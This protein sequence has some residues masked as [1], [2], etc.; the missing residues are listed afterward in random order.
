MGLGAIAAFQVGTSL[1]RYAGARYSA[2]KRNFGRTAIGQKLSQIEK[3]GAISPEMRNQRLGEENRVL[4]SQSSAATAR[5]RGGLINRGLDDSIAGVRAEAAPAIEKLRQLGYS[6]RGI[7]AENA[8]SK[9]NAGLQRAELETAYN[10]ETKALK[11]QALQNLIGG[12]GNAAVGYATGKL[13]EAENLRLENK[14]DARYD[15]ARLDKITAST[16]VQRAIKNYEL[17]GDADS[18]YQRLIDEGLSKDE[19]LKILKPLATPDGA[20]VEDQGFRG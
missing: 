18:L 20:R 10:D 8:Q 2:S 1:A 17:D 19:I 11:A 6:A 15:Q 16:V 7:A 12:V 14:A 13:G 4:S 5:I 9:I 3:E